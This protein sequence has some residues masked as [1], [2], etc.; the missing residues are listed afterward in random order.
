[1]ENTILNVS[2]KEYK[3]AIDDLRSS[4]L[5]L[6]EDSEEYKKTVKEITEMQAKLDKV[7]QDTSKQ[8]LAQEGSYN[9]LTQEMSRLK[10]IWKETSSFRSSEYF[11]T[12]AG[13]RRMIS[14]SGQAENMIPPKCSFTAVNSAKSDTQGFSARNMSS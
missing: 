5:G 12:A 11:R 1:M 2:L 7:M 3:K 4:L 9:R 6:D 8:V 13:V 10:K 14:R